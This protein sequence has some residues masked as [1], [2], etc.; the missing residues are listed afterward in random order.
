MSG[1]RDFSSHLLEKKIVSEQMQWKDWQNNVL[2]I[3]RQSACLLITVQ[4]RLRNE[5]LQIFCNHHSKEYNFSVE[6][7]N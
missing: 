6:K 3:L 5:E 2:G 1:L 7:K 4:D